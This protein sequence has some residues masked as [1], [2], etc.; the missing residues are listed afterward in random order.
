MK[1]SI[2][3][4]AAL[5][6]LATLP[7]SANAAFCKLRILADIPAGD[8]HGAI[9]KGD[10][11]Q[12]ASYFTREPGYPLGVFGEE[13]GS[14]VPRYI[15]IHGKVVEAARPANCTILKNGELSFIDPHDRNIDQVESKI[16]NRLGSDVKDF[17]DLARYEQGN[18]AYMYAHKPDGKCARLVDYALTGNRN[19]I[20]ILNSYPPYCQSK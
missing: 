4:V 10:S 18:I 5:A 15:R 1:I 8:Q 9:R 7:A 13:G 3:T 16:E 12:E 6:A 2:W 11:D 20:R 19:A 14:L 17:P